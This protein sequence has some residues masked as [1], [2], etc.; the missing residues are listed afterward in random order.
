MKW[1]TARFPEGPPMRVQGIFSDL[2]YQPWLCA[3]A[4][5]R[6]SWL[7]IDNLERR[8]RLSPP[9]FRE[10]YERPNRPVVLTDVVRTL[11][12]RSALSW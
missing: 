12:T 3:T 7:Q 5:L 9:E 2:L 4:P 6:S 11:F 10:E 8:S 1:P